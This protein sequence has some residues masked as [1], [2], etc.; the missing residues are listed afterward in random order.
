MSGLSHE[1]LC[2]LSRVFVDAGGLWSSQDQRIHEWLKAQIEAA[3]SGDNQA[4]RDDLCFC[5][6]TP[7][8]CATV[9]D[10]Q[11]EAGAGESDPA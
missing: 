11:C 7:E 5:G 8:K 9:P 6:F 1:D 3:Q 2:H 4:K 10:S